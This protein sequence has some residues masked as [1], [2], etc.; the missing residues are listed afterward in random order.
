MRRV[1]ALCLVACSSPSSEPTKSAPSP[2]TAPPV[3]VSDAAAPS[4]EAPTFGAPAPQP[5]EP[6]LPRRLWTARH[7]VPI[8]AVFATEDG[9]AVVSIDESNH[10]RLWPAL[11]GTR[12]PLALPLA[13]PSE[14]VVVRDG[15]GFA[16]AALDVSGGLE[17][18]AV[19]AAGELTAHV[20]REPEPG[21]ATLV[22][23]DGGFLV[24]HR[25]QTLELLDVKG[26][27]RAAVL[28]AP[29]EHVLGLLHRNGR[30]LAI[31]RTKE[32]V[33]G[34]WL[35]AA[36]TGAAA[37]ALAWG[38]LTPK[39]RVNLERV[40]LSP[41]HERLVTFFEFDFQSYVVD[42]A[43]GRSTQFEHR[44][45]QFDS[46]DGFPVG[47]ASAQ[48][49]V[50]AVSDFELSQLQWWTVKGHGT[51]V[52]GGSD[53]ALEFVAMNSAVATD[54]NVISFSG[55]ELAIATRNDARNPSHVKYLGY[56]TNRAKAVQ[57]SPVGVV[58]AIGSVAT[59][60]DDDVRVARR[61]PALQAIPL[62]QDLAL[63]KLTA[64][65]WGEPVVNVTSGIDPSWLEGTPA[66]AKTNQS[67]PGLALYDLDTKKELQRWAVPRAFHFE[68]ASQLLA[69]DRGSK[70]ELAT[71]DPAA[72]SF[73]A[74]HAIAGAVTRV[75]LLDPKLTGGL[76]ALLVRERGP[77]V[78]V[79]AV[80]G[81]DAAAPRTLTGT[82]EAIDRAGRLYLRR[83]GEP[84]DT[85][86]VEREGHE[87]ARLAVPKGWAIRP[88]PTGN[89]LAT[90]A[91]SRLSLLDASGATVWSV[92]FPGITDAAWTASG[93]L[94]VL[95][96]D[97]AK[98][99][100]AT[101]RVV[102]AQCGWG[103][104]LRTYRPEPVDFPSTTETACD[105]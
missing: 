94:V 49:I 8:A 59:L 103:F 33:R 101:G 9:G 62:A 12:E 25:D 31:V 67:R 21:V 93:D 95:A 81:V 3:A 104:A 85:L 23:H 39:L 18:L 75:A 22:E 61:V 83:A 73:G 46:S 55:H 17:V 43:T 89:E 29:G 88:S 56:R 34:H 76:T 11:D 14:A 2:A 71:F 6:A 37:A 10:A 70:V 47:F 38:E 30:T 74:P 100:V 51:A 90:F 32:G 36:G 98:V 92:G 79:R 105:H 16:I 54:A 35:A 26:T 63:I 15:G 96:G 72:R 7:G 1:L 82:L 5:A 58:A 60:L 86:V 80:S 97:I 65:D 77:T 57:S 19:D 28:P 64:K 50:F 40:F 24:V 87:P 27:R 66:R 91:R 84:E 20:K 102:A 41:D 78:E 42:L 99:D 52:V 48:Q 69:I 44:R 45:S 53:Y 4:V 13:T 68:P